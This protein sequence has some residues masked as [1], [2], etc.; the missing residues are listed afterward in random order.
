MIELNESNLFEIISKGESETLEF[1]TNLRD[2]ATLAKHL[3]AFANSKGGTLLVGVREPN[4]V[5]G[6]DEKRIA[7]IVGRSKPMLSP[8]LDVHTQAIPVNGKWVVAI[9]V[10]PSPEVVFSDGQV[11]ARF[12]DTIQRLPPERLA[13]KLGTV[14]GKSS[15]DS[16]AESISKQT[17][18]IEKLRGELQEASGL[19]SKM[20]DYLIGGAIGAIMGFLLSLLLLIK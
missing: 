8:A 2:P 4:I 14:I 13:A 1:K 16:L 11:L 15:I 7:E 6:T 3:A 10:G 18:I 9:S 12:G 20:K 17:A 5:V 19:K